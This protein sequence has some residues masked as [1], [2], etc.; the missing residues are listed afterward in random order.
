MGIV[1]NTH[2]ELER[3]WN[4]PVESIYDSRDAYPRRALPV[5]NVAYQ[6]SCSTCYTRISS[7]WVTQRQRKKRRYCHYSAK[8]H[9]SNSAHWKRVLTRCLP[10]GT[11]RRKTMG[12]QR[13]YASCPESVKKKGGWNGN[14][15]PR[16]RHHGQ[17]P[18]FHDTRNLRRL[19][20]QG[21]NLITHNK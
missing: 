4:K 8:R 17:L 2:W 16:W 11:W 18:K 6:I 3:G 7:V 9:Q 15:E 20:R 1:G 13:L 21:R 19:E 14:E 10:T 5:R 12:R